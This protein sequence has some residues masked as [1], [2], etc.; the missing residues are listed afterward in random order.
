MPKEYYRTLHE[1][2]WGLYKE[3]PIN[4]R[5]CQSD[6]VARS[7][8]IRNEVYPFQDALFR[9]RFFTT[10]LYLHDRIVL[11]TIFNEGKEQAVGKEMRFTLCMLGENTY[12]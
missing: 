1:L 10:R 6:I 12:G 4:M 7:T 9:Q 5:G 11:P 3:M 8:N 2:T